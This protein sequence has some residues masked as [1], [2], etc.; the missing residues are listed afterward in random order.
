MSFTSSTRRRIG[1]V[2]IAA[3][4]AV[5][6]VSIP[7]PAQAHVT[8]VPSAVAS[9]DAPIKGATYRGVGDDVVRIQRTRLPCIITFTHSGSRNFIV[10]GVD[11]KGEPSTYLVNEIGRYR[12]TKA[13]NVEYFD[14]DGI[15]A[16]EVTADGA[17]S[18]VVRPLTSAR[19]WKGAT[20][21]GSGDDVVKLTPAVPATGVRTLALTHV[22]SSNFL[23]HSVVG[24]RTGSYLV[25]AI[26]RYKGRVRLPVRT[27][28]LVIDADGAWSLVRR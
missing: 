27:Q 2:A 1:S 23:V 6:L 25:N 10:H 20:L 13:F 16:L 12:G 11:L 21:G 14:T 8:A 26:G 3:L 28:Y 17:W 19:Q 15:A 9:A 22:G 24:G 18:A 5:V 7:G 4:A